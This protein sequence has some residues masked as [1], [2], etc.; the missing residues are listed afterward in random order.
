M[1]ID[2]TM[3]RKER[4]NTARIFLQSQ[5]G[6]NQPATLFPANRHQ[7]TCKVSSGIKVHTTKFLPARN[8]TAGN[9]RKELSTPGES[10]D[11]FYDLLAEVLNLCWICIFVR[12]RLANL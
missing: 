4:A 12:F 9:H 11:I 3:G 7:P 6:R 1:I 8:K 2:F 5:R 10:E